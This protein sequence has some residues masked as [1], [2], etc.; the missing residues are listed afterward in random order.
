[1]HRKVT[2][3]LSPISNLRT[4]DTVDGDRNSEEQ[5]S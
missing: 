3:G 5:E 1:M 2:V 4:E